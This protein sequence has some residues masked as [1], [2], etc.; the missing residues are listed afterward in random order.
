MSRRAIVVG[1]GLAGLTAAHALRQRGDEPLVLEASDHPGGKL[2]TTREDGWLLEWGPQSFLYEEDTAFLR[3]VSWAGLEDAVLRPPQASRKRFV[4]HRGQLRAMPGQVHRILSLW[5]L[6]RAATELFVLRPQSHLALPGPAADGQAPAAGESVTAFATRRFGRQAAER[7]FGTLV[8]GVFAGDPDRLEVASAFPKLV[9]LE[10]RYGSVIRAVLRGG[11][12]PR[13]LAGLKGGMGSLAEALAERLGDA[14]HLGERA[15]EVRRQGE[16]WAVHTEH[17]ELSADAVIVTTPAFA[18]ADLLEPLD[19]A[20]ADD[21]R[22][23]PYASLAAVCLGYDQ[24]AFPS[25]PPQGFGF[26]VPRAEGLRTLGC[27]FPSAIFEEAA[28]PG[29]VL[30]R[31]LIGGRLDPDAASLPDDEL[32][33]LARREVEPVLGVLGAPERTWVFTHTQAIPQYELG[34]AE[35]IKQIEARLALRPGLLLSG[36]PYRGVSLI[37]VAA[38]AERMAEVV[39]G[40][41]LGS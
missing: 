36:N 21:L 40:L 5:G 11:F 33:A 38:D 12:Q 35:R 15:L 4:L 18:A 7:L 31:V 32:V 19:R 13:G 14:L 3:A 1:A 25:G 27:L 2:R 39:A 23:I 26:L 37:D 9:A 8:S 6:A 28:P 29:K 20:L 16:G 10:E 30:L 24:S 41:E 22:Q 17:A 34:H